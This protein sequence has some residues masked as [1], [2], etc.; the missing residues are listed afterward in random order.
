MV[1]SEYPISITR[2]FETPNGNDASKCD[3]AKSTDGASKTLNNTL[4]TAYRYDVRDKIL[5]T[6]TIRRSLATVNKY[7]K[8]IS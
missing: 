4:A 8:N 3:G 6:I 7:L 1:A 2:A 5:S